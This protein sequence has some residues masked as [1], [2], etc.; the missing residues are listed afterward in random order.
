MRYS[1]R[2]EQSALQRRDAKGVVHTIYN[3]VEKLHQCGR[4]LC[5]S[6]RILWCNELAS[7]NDSNTGW[8]FTP[9][10][11][12]HVGCEQNNKTGHVYRRNDDY[13]VRGK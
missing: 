5:Y 12:T 9:R 6:S 3:D 13:N 8:V 1:N 2:V 4:R 7:Y 11:V 10:D